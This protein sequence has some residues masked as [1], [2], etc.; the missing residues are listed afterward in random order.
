[1]QE[2]CTRRR[3][4]PRKPSASDTLHPYL[5]LIARGALSGPPCFI[6]PIGS[7]ATLFIIGT[8]RVAAVGNFQTTCTP[9]REPLYP[10]SEP[11]TLSLTLLNT[12]QQNTLHIHGQP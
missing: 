2:L 10:S 1:V 3:S 8:F 5:P 11:Y 6:A 7:S 9:F 12:L 4:Q